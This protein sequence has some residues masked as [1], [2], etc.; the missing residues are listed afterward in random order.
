MTKEELRNAIYDDFVTE[1]YRSNLCQMSE[2]EYFNM[3]QFS[4]S[5]IEASAFELM[6]ELADSAIETM[7]DNGI[8]K[9]KKARV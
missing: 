3:E 8:L 2:N 9:A 4:L 7:Q 1:Y 6:E 5:A